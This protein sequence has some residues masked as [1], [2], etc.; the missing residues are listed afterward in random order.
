MDAG[1]LMAHGEMFNGRM[2]HI[3]IHGIDGCSRDAEGGF[4][5][6]LT[7]DLHNSLCNCHLHISFSFFSLPR[8]VFIVDFYCPSTVYFIVDFHYQWFH[9]AF[10]R[11]TT[12]MGAPARYAFT[13]STVQSMILC[14]LSF[15]AQEM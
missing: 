8:F 15:G 5:A 1:L 3:F 6:F 2:L 13:F 11:F 10:Y 9:F 4:Y 14:L 7:H 12:W